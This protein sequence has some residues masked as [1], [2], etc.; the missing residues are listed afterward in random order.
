MKKFVLIVILCFLPAAAFATTVDPT[1][2][3]YDW[4]KVATSGL[5]EQLTSISYKLFFLLA[6]IQISV[7]LFG[8]MAGGDMEAALGKMIKWFLWVSFC[9][10]LMLNNI[11]YNFIANTI[12]YFLNHAISWTTNSNGDF[13]VNGIIDSGLTGFSDTTRAVEKSVLPTSK[14]GLMFFL[15]GGGSG[16]LA[17]VLIAALT[18]GIVI[19]TIIFTTAYIALKVFMI[20]I[21]SALILAVLPFNLSLLGLNALRDQGFAPF[22]SMLALIYRI[23]IMGI[24]VGGMSHVGTTINTY[25]N[26]DADPNILQM[27]LVAVFGY[28]LLA[29]IAFKAD[30]IAASL[31][32]GS[33]NL[34][35]GDMI[36]AAIAGATAGGIAAAAIQGAM[37]AAGG[38]ASSIKS[39]GDVL[40]DMNSAGSINNA[41]G[42]GTGATSEPSPAPTRAMASLSSSAS[43]SSGSGNSTSSTG[44]G[45]PQRGREST[46]SGSSS[47]SPSAQTAPSSAPDQGQ[48][49]QS[50]DTSSTQQSQNV[51]SPQTSG[52]APQPT[53]SDSQPASVGGVPQRDA[54]QNNE[55]DVSKAPKRDQ[56]KSAGQKLQDNIGKLANITSQEKHA[57]HVSI[58]THPHD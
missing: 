13:S 47:S 41:S 45:A 35:S 54:G 37:G 22:K 27:A 49:T 33:A 17:S 43:P 31:A 8:Q 29:F 1:S 14:T 2:A 9:M 36:G 30:Q 46:D 32:A 55:G 12:Q 26:S 57:T 18:L 25:A 52:A 51:S 7:T 3:T 19:I 11:A 34:G 28:L 50:G 56:E 24:V 23:I 38:A 48:A 20:K 5:T 53:G 4:V 42:R 44:G 10:Y 40:K 39:M 6:L 21:E 58:N 16:A 15:T